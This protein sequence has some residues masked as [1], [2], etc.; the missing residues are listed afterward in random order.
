M[1]MPAMTSHAARETTGRTTPAPVDPSAMRM[2]ISARRQATPYAVT[3]YS[4][5]P[6]SRRAS[7][8]KNRDSI[9]TIRS[10][11]SEALT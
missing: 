11:V 10:C 1:K 2:P 6:A 8:A 7:A 4:P 5:S 9:A 3:P